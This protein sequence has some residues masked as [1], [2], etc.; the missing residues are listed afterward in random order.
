MNK[1]LRKMVKIFGSVSQYPSEQRDYE[2]FSGFQS[3]RDNSL[4]EFGQIVF[5]C[6]SDFFDKAVQMK[7]FEHAC[8]LMGGFVGKVFSDSAVAQ[9]ADVEFASCN[10]ME[11]I[12]IIAVKKVEA[13]IAAAIVA[14][15][16]RNLFDVFL[17]RT[18][19]VDGGDE[20]DIAAIGSGHQFGKHIQT[21]DAFLQRRKLYLAGAVAVF[22]P[23]VVF[24]KGNV[25][26]GCFDTQHKAVLIVHF[27]C[28]RSHVMFNAC[29][30]YAG[31]EV[32]AHFVLIIAVKISLTKLDNWPK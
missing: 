16:V 28:Y 14:D 29:S 3:D 6:S 9:A 22:H 10:S 5:V 23:P 7:P 20:I 31:V 30:L 12:Q 11:Q 21:V 1:I 18:G 24:E 13:A 27:D 8:Y 4:A 17:G 32:V 25:V 19:I 15:G 26:D 2:Q